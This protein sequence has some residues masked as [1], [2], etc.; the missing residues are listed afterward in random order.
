MY[1]IFVVVVAAQ[2]RQ[3]RGVLKLFFLVPAQVERGKEVVARE[4]ARL[5]E[6]TAL[7]A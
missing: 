7:L 4:S 5:S 3:T 1:S 6:H 2:H